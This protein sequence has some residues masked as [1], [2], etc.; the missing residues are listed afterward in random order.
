MGIGDW[1]GTG[2]RFV[3]IYDGV[4]QYAALD[5]TWTPTTAV[6]NVYF[7]G[8]LLAAPS[9]TT[10]PFIGSLT[11]PL[12]I[13]WRDGAVLVQ[14]EDA[15]ATNRYASVATAK[16]PGETINIDLDVTGTRAILTVDGVSNTA[17]HDFTTL[18]PHVVGSFSRWGSTYA[19]VAS[20]N[21]GLVDSA[22]GSNS[23]FYPCDEPSGSV[24]LNAFNSVDATLVNSPS[25]LEV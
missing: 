18:T 7:A 4:N 2:K 20:A 14:I 9:A 8:I 21:I 15:T 25:R 3:P 12:V 22:D 6:W 17:T 5:S 19:N 11:D 13:Y 1:R 24:L 16:V 10:V 23:R